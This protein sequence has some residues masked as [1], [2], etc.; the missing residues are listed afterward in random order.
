VVKNIFPGGTVANLRLNAKPTMTKALGAEINAVDRIEGSNLCPDD[1]LGPYEIAE[2]QAHFHVEDESGNVL[3]D[4]DKTV[5]C[6]SG[7]DNP[8]KFIVTFSG[9]NCGLGGYNTGTFD[10][11]TTVSANGTEKSRTQKIRCR[12]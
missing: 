4:V 7:V 2:A 8:N 5:E 1:P 9:E 11:Y 12:P 3:L 10:I 6:V